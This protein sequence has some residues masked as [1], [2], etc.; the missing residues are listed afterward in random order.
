LEKNLR[1]EAIL[2]KDGPY[3]GY[4]I[5]PYYKWL[6]RQIE[7]GFHFVIESGG[8]SIGKYYTYEDTC[9]RYNYF[10]YVWSKDA[11]LFDIKDTC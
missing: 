5:N 7:G 11:T 10:Q 9:D 4:Y 6:C 2:I 1:L 8:Q 3:K